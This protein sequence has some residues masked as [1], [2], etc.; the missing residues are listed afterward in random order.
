MTDDARP[1]DVIVVG[2]GPAGSASATALAR[3]GR[4]VLL[5]ERRGGGAEF[6]VGESLPPQGRALLRELGVERR[7][8]GDAHAPSYANQSAWGTAALRSTDFVM[9]RH[10]HGWHLD[11]AKFDA[12]LRDA[13][14]EAGAAILEDA[15]ACEFARGG[16]GLWRVRV[17]SR[18]EL[19]APWLLDCTGR[20]SLVARGRGV[21]RVNHDRLLGFVSLFRAQVSDRD[22]TTLVESVPHG[23]WYTARLPDARR[24]AVYFTDADAETAPAARDAGGFARLLGETAHVRRRLEGYEASAPPRAT[25]ANTA[26]LAEFTGDGWLAAGDAAASFDPLSSQGICT[27][28]YS[29]LR[30]GAALARRLAGDPDS[31]AQYAAELASVFDAYLTHRSAFY[32]HE[33]RWPQ[34]PFW[35]RRHVHRVMQTTFV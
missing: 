23:W 1:W 2:G 8:D 26:R 4:R 30:A 13:A 22:S 14:R 31:L 24:V 29:G 12:M 9:G 10:G 3:A 19:L 32:G 33:R 21:P 5:A 25:A 16:D 7:F 15:H 6:K 20:A 27:A 11:R 35:K 28:I 34:R 18:G 17:P